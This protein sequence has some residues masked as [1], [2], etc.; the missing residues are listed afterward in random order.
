MWFLARVNTSKSGVVSYKEE[1]TFIVG[2][3]AGD[4]YIGAYQAVSLPPTSWRG[5]SASSWH[6]AGSTA[7]C[8]LPLCRLATKHLHTPP[9]GLIRA[10]G[11]GS[12][13]S[14]TGSQDTH[15]VV[16][17]ARATAGLSGGSGN[18]CTLPSWVKQSKQLLSLLHSQQQEGCKQQEG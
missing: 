2:C 13:H 9:T 11:G 8:L 6:L 17:C 4:G 14:L 1:A 3:Q 7:T 15:K 16:V 18:H 5:R 12:S 10:D